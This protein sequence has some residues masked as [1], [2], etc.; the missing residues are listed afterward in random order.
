MLLLLLLRPGP[1]PKG[2]RDEGNEIPPPNK[3]QK[4]TVFVKEEEN[5]SLP[6]SPSSNTCGIWESF[7]LHL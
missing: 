2:S 5:L 3:A 1:I 7:S 6:F 4:T